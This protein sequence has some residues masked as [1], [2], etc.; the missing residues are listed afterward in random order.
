MPVQPIS[1]TIQELFTDVALTYLTADVAS[2]AETLSVKALMILRLIRF[3]LLEI[4]EIK[5]QK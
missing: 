5:I 3:C 2:A 4:L 1:T